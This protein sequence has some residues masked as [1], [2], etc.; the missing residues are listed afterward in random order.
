MQFLLWPFA[1]GLFYVSLLSM[2]DPSDPTIGFLLDGMDR[3]SCLVRKYI[4]G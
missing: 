4:A 3:L 1:L 2:Q